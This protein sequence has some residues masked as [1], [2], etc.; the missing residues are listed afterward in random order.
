MDNVAFIEKFAYGNN[1]HHPNSSKR[2]K[3]FSMLKAWCAHHG[4]TLSDT[5]FDTALANRFGGG[6]EIEWGEEQ[7]PVA[8]PEPAA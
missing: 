8:A 2:S 4:R 5:E 3:E 7:A 1:A 6:C